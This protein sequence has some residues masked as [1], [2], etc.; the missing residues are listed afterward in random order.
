MDKIQATH[1]EGTPCGSESPA[2]G[3]EIEKALAASRTPAFGESEFA[4]RFNA[5]PYESQCD[6]LM[7]LDEVLRFVL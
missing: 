1:V 3:R 2:K 4:I 5:F 6:H 7:A